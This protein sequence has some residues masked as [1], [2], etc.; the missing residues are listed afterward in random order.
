MNY[1]GHEWNY[2]PLKTFTYEKHTFTISKEKIT[3]KK[4]RDE[5]N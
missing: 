2:Q 4:K 3:M 1:C 5:T